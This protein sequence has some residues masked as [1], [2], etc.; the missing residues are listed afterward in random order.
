MSTI[1]SPASILITG[2]TGGLGRALAL[3]YAA[4]A[5]TLILH[6]RDAAKLAAL[7]NECGQRGAH[8]IPLLVDLRDRENLIATL[9]ALSVT[10]PIDLA[11]VNAG[12]TNVVGTSEDGGVESWPDIERVLD[13]VIC[14][15]HTQV[16]G[17]L[18][19]E[20][21][22]KNNKALFNG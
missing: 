8:V 7:Q 16:A 11:I 18:A 10:T 19:A 12:G 14:R 5:I 20:H 4:P 21:A 3:A 6:G 22:L 1:S 13:I 17:H 15:I 9:G 2:A